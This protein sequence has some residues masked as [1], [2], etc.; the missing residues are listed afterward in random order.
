MG[1]SHCGV[2]TLRGTHTEG[3]GLVYKSRGTRD[4][5]GEGEIVDP[6]GEGEVNHAGPVLPQCQRYY[7][8]VNLLWVRR[9]VWV[10]VSVGEKV[11]VGECECVWE[12]E[13]VILLYTA[14]PLSC[15]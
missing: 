7:S 5:G 11:C 14:T 9:C 1:Y 13:C 3:C 8:N 10:S 6:D 12:R 4:L 15:G 2:L